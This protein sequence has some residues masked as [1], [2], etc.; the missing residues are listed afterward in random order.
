MTDMLK[1]IT[2]DNFK[3]ERATAMQEKRYES[4]EEWAV[5][6]AANS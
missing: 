2:L 4:K 3:K 5:L 6:R 1:N